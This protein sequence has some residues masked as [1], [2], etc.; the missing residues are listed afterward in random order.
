MIVESGILDG[1][2]SSCRMFPDKIIFKFENRILSVESIDHW[3][4]FHFNRISLLN[5]DNVNS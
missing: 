4:N 5:Y 3:I 1:I 2:L